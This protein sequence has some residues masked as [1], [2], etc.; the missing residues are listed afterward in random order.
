MPAPPAEKDAAVCTC[1]NSCQMALFASENVEGAKDVKELYMQVCLLQKD[2]K[3]GTQAKILIRKMRNFDTIIDLLKKSNENGWHLE[4][5][6]IVSINEW[7]DL[8]IDLLTEYVEAKTQNLII[9]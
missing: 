4:A 8:C 1:V 3:F 5:S 6:M 7:R 2:D 9:H